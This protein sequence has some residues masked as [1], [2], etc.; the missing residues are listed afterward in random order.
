[1]SE[2]EFPKAQ[3]LS[4][5]ELVEQIKEA[6]SDGGRFCFILGAGASVESGIPTGNKLEKIWMDCLMGVADDGKTEKRN[7]NS[8]RA[9]AEKIAKQLDHPFAEIEQAW[10][11]VR[12]G[13]EKS[14]PSVYYFD[15]Y[16]LRFPR[17]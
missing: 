3:I 15:I 6:N 8:T 16:R 9:R 4:A 1:M 13:K 10:N 12:D 7:P 17:L 5:V 2:I 14:I 11:D